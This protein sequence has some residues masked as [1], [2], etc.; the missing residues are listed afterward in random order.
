MLT[1]RER[2]EGLIEVKDNGCWLW[3]GGLTRGGYGNFRWDTTK[4]RRAHRA[5][6]EIYKETIPEGL[7]VCHR[8]DVVSCVNP[9]HLFLGTQ[10]ENLK[11]MVNKGRHKSHKACAKISWEDV[12]K[13]RELRLQGMKLQPIADMFLIG[14]DEVCR[15]VNNKRWKE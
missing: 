9:D 6:W 12:R 2:F 14:A 8:C 11:D 13:I 3:I 15:I 5:S 4:V 10:T 1:R 7:Q